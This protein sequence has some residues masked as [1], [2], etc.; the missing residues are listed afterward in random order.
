METL[1]ARKDRNVLLLFFKI[2]HNMVPS[3]LQEL[4]PDKKKPGR[5]MFRTKKDFVEPGWRITKYKKS[6]LSFA[7]SRWNRLDENTRKITNYESFKGTLMANTIDTPLFYVGSRQEQ[8]IMAKL[9]MGCSNLNGHLYSMKLIDSPAIM[10]RAGQFVFVL[11]DSFSSYTV[12]RILPNERSD[13]VRGAI[14]EC[15]A[16]LKSP[17][18]CILRG[19]GAMSCLASEKE[20]LSHNI[21]IEVGRLKNPNKNP[22]AEKAIQELEREIKTSHPDSQPISPASLAIITSRL[23]SSVRNRGL[24]ASEIAFQRDGQTG[25]QLNITGKLLA[26][27]QHVNRVANHGPSAKCQSTVPTPAKRFDVSIG[28]LVYIKNEG[29]KH[30]S[31]HKYI[32]VAM[33]KDFLSVRK[34]T[35][36]AFWFKL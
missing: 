11:R 18:G 28:D 6:V 21:V 19:D 25:E 30:N 29:D 34:L 1:K 20:L 31:R 32:V 5:Y 12:S 27:D 22:Q 2:I 35:G 23:N 7:I 10:R 9:R 13:T 8:I 14:I 26:D 33:D 3:Y 16:E 4:K 24:S 15:I 36:S 17:T